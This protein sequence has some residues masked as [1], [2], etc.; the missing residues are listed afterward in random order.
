MMNER[1][2]EAILARLPDAEVAAV[3][4]GNRAEIT[5]ISREFVGMSRVRKQQA[6]YACINDLIADGTLHAVSIRALTPDEGR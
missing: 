6:V 2:A 3:V 5:V 4:D 1:I